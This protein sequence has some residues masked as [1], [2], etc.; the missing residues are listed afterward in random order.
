MATDNRK[1]IRVDAEV[2]EKIDKIAKTKHLKVKEIVRY[3]V[4]L[5][6]I[7][8]FFD[9]NWKDALIQDRL[10]E[11][12]AKIQADFDERMEAKKLDYRLKV[13]RDLLLRYIDTMDPEDRRE[14][15]EERMGEINDPTFIDQ[16]GNMDVV[17]LD[18]K[19]KLVRFVDG[20]PIFAGID[21]NKIIPC[22]VGYHVKDNFC[23]CKRWREC[24]V[25][26]E[27]YTDFRFRTSPEGRKAAFYRR[28]E[29]KGIE[30]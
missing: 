27:E 15:I 17:V 24:K 11:Y 10:E 9:V 14:F 4:D 23:Q 20:T 3:L 5:T 13:K 19:R 26:S 1:T 25:R 6:D 30:I 22:D 16:L 18:G 12:K 7:V 2:K 8:D 21:S 29:A 28:K